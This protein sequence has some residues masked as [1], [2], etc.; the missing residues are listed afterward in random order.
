M[1]KKTLLTAKHALTKPHKNTFFRYK[2]LFVSLIPPHYAATLNAFAFTSWK[3]TTKL[4][5][6]YFIKQSYLIL[7]W[8]YHLKTITRSFESDRNQLG[9]KRMI[10]F[11]ILPSR[12][13]HY[14]LLKS[15]MAQKKKLQGAVLI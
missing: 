3:D 8:F 15:P 4:P 12:R 13:S 10:K 14:T 5:N 6:K 1:N 9:N 7:A 2:V 11:I